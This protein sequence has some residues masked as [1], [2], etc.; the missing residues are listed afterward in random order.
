MK[1]EAILVPLNPGIHRS[2]S[3]DFRARI[4]TNS[5]QLHFNVR[6]M[7]QATAPRQTVVSL[8]LP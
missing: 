7:E 8:I 1:F 3:L 5:E 4:G 6:L 2:N